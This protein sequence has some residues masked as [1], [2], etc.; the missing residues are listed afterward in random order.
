MS[1]LDGMTEDGGTLGYE[2][3]GRFARVAFVAPAACEGYDVGN[4]WLLA[5][6]VAVVGIDCFIIID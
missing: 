5:V 4:Y 1:E 2:T 6:A 3:H